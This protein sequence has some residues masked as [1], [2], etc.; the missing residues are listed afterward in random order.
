M[1]QVCDL[2]GAYG[3]TFLMTLFAAGLCTSL[4]GR[5]FSG[6]AVSGLVL[7]AVLGY[8]VIKLETFEQIAG[9]PLNVVVVQGNIDTRFPAT[10]A[11]LNE[12]RQQ[13]M[14]DYR[15]LQRTW[16]KQHKGPAAE[17]F[18]WPEGKYPIPYFLPGG[19]KEEAACREYFRDFHATLFQ[20]G[21]ENPLTPDE[22]PFPLMIVGASTVDP[23]NDKQYNSA[24]LLGENGKVL[25]AYHKME[26]V[27]FGEFIPFSKWFPILGKIT[28]VGNG[29]DRG[30]QPVAFNINDNIAM[31]FVCFESA[32]THHVRESIAY[33]RS[34][35]KDPDLLVNVTDD[36]WFYGQTALD[37][38]LACN[39]MRA[40][41]NR[42][43]LVVSANTGL[44]AFIQSSGEIVS[45]G[46]RR[47]SE[48]LEQELA[49]KSSTPLYATVGDWPVI[50]MTAMC[51]LAILLPRRKTATGK[52]PQEGEG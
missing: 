9:S 24:L 6:L 21:R 39:V 37:Q 2:F 4:C 52:S 30:T 35:G 20:A 41:E 16:L 31:P 15:N 32:I 17:L 29:I 8:G 18:V 43:P 12:Y 49:L 3:L 44:S 38:H 45:L 42:K 19:G 7:A 50:L 14:G 51:I 11:E 48:V 34:L 10:E 33:L 40:V 27:P 25:S 47:N 28:P 46:P 1:L 26:L 36:G 5:R 13:L 22:P 23:Q